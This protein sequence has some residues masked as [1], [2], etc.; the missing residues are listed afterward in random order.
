LTS[1]ALLALFAGASDP[2]SPLATSQ[3]ITSNQAGAHAR[4]A[5]KAAP[6]A[7]K[8]DALK[9]YGRLPIT[10]IP[11]AGQLT[12][13]VRYYAQGSGYAFA[14]TRTGVRLG[15]QSKKQA[16]ALTLN[17]LKA[18]PNP[19]VKG[20]AQGP[21]RVNYLAGDQ[22]EWRTGLPTYGRLVY[23]DLWPGID[24]VFRGEGSRLIYE[25]MVK[26]GGRVEDIRLQYTG[27]KALSLDAS[28]NLV[29]RT[30]LGMLK[31]E[32]P[33]TYQLDGGRRVP[34]ASAF[35]ISGAADY[36]FSIGQH[37]PHLPLLIDPGLIYSSYLGGSSLEIGNAIAVDSTGHAYVTGQTL[38]TNFPTTPGAFDTTYNGCCADAFVTKFN[39]SGSALDYSTYLGGNLTDVGY[40]IRVDAAG[41][42]FVAGSTQSSNFPTTPGAFQ[43]TQLQAN[44]VDAFVTKLNSTGSALVYSTRLGGHGGDVA[45]GI[46]IDALGDAYVT[47]ATASRD[48]PTTPLAFDTTFN[49]GGFDAFVTKLNPF[50]TAPLLYS[51]FLGGSGYDQGTGIDI[52]STGS[53][54]VTG[55]TSSANFPTTATSF[56]ITYNGSFDA[57]VTKLNPAGSAP[58]LYSTYLGGSGSD[59]ARGIVIDSA[60]P[61]NAY[62]T[63]STASANFPTMVGSY[64]LIYNGN[65]DAFVTKINGLGTAPLV[66]STYL[67]GSNYDDGRAIALDSSGDAHVTGL[68]L[69][70]NFPTTPGAYDTH[71]DGFDDAFLSKF[72]AT[73]SVLL[74]S[75]YLGGSYYDDGYGVTLDGSGAVYLTGDTG[76]TNFP[77]TPGAFDTSYNGGGDAFV[78]KLLA[79][80]APAHLD[81]QPVTA[82]NMVGQQHCVT[83]TVTDAAGQPVPGVTVVFS[84][85][86]AAETGASPASGSFTTNSAGQATFCYTA[87]LPGVDTITAF[88]DTNNNGQQ[89]VG[90][91]FGLATKTWT[92]PV[93]SGTCKITD[94]GWITA[95]NGD[96]G[97]FSGEV[98]VAGGQASGHETYEDRGPVRPERIQSTSL[99]AVVCPTAAGRAAQIYGHATVNGMGD[100]IFLI[101]VTDGG[102]SGKNDTYGIMV[103]D[104]YVSGQEPLGGGNINIR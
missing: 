49:Q 104:G 80:G 96:R 55:F 35:E 38:S 89:D 16:D 33:A 21:G 100:Y 18:S 66:Y 1:A 62:V 59:M 28:G 11:N 76:S 72:N 32:P 75:T 40:G 69:S 77:T 71:L 31:D 39:S 20:Q 50:G 4:A 52:D 56:D 14:F 37:D 91:P 42:A 26:P 64:D 24:M 74:Y 60:V 6:A 102:N 36:G 81:L 85:P 87:T 86:T 27:Q 97:D 7:S 47:G 43:T 2:S 70:S 53:A 63:G 3:R 51:T 9:A 5:D 15:F 90:E 46:Q 22:R 8:Q 29:A 30:A 82:T 25:F 57:F 67:G 19:V 34:V 10:F 65:T 41:E 44:D 23:Q 61:P 99:L 78:T 84:V 73:G 83:A 12:G 92:P 79:V 88:A 98:H 17:F 58:L 54:Y 94:S 93:T 45:Y 103:S 68:T 101:T 13:D 95:I 48:F